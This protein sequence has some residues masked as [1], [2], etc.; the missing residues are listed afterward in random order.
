MGEQ[1]HLSMDLDEV[2]TVSIFILFWLCSVMQKKD[3]YMHLFFQTL[4]QNLGI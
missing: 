4:N 3:T 2:S 1:S